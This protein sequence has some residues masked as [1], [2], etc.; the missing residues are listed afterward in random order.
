VVE[1]PPP[2]GDDDMP[3]TPRDGPGRDDDLDSLSSDMDIPLPGDE[4]KPAETP[5]EDMVKVGLG[6]AFLFLRFYKLVTALGYDEIQGNK[7]M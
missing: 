4:A 7:Q 1:L 5:R 3:A 2:H 6:Q